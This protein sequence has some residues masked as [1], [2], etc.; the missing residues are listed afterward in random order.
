MVITGSDGDR[1]F[2]IENI[3]G[4]AHNDTL[5]GSNLANSLNGGAGDD[6]ITGGAGADAID[7]GSGND[8][9]S[10]EASNAAVRV[11]LDG[12]AGVGGHAQGDTL[13]NIEHVIGSSHVDHLF[14]SGGNDHLEGNAGNDTL[15]GGSG[16]DT[17]SG[18]AGLDRLEGGQGDDVL[19][20]NDTL[21]GNEG[22]DTLTGGTGADKFVLTLANPQN[23]NERISS[24]D[25]IL[26]F[27]SADGDRIRIDTDR[28]H[29]K[30]TWG[31]GAQRCR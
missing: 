25:T 26:D 4:S 17:L 19:D 23:N 8:T 21:F 7:G 13:T 14:G 3:T 1:L 20:G 22:A 30:F 15:I 9:A 11:Y 5:T 29:R 10:Y 24:V 31:F 18:G 6:I 28:W 16:A 12:T 27:N 2:N